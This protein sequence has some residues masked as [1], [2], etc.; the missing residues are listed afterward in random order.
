[1]EQQIKDFLG[2]AEG[3]YTLYA[4][5]ILLA[6][7]GAYLVCAMLQHGGCSRFFIFACVIGYFI[8]KNMGIL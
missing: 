1:M 4:V 6:T 3:Q 8:L 7:G 2:T 5:V